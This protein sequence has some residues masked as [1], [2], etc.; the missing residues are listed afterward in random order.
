M[1]MNGGFVAT[2]ARDCNWLRL[3]LDEV[4][5]SGRNNCTAD[6]RGRKLS[7]LGQRPLS[8]WRTGPMTGVEKIRR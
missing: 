1:T 4:N 6:G 2:L 7:P 8:G 5:A 3:V